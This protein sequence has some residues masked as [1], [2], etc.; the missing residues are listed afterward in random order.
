MA[1]PGIG[2]GHLARS[3]VAANALH[4]HGLSPRLLVHSPP[5]RRDD[6]AVLPH[7]FLAP[8]SP[9]APA[10]A[11]AARLSKAGA[12]LFDLYPP[13][14]SADLDDLLK[15][16]RAAG[17]R[18]V[19][20]DGLL[21]NAADLDLIFIPSFSF[22]PPADLPNRTRVLYGWDCYL[23]ESSDASTPWR[24]GQ[25][26]LALTGGSD[27]TG[28]GENLPGRLNAE[29]PEHAELDW[30]TGPFA[31]QPVW[32]D[33]PRIRMTNRQ[34][35]QGLGGLMRTAHY[36]LT[37]FGVSF[38]ELLRHGVPT[39]VFS[40]YGGKDDAELSGIAEAGVA[41]TAR[42]EAEAV[43]RLRALMA[44]D[45]LAAK[46]SDAALRRMATPGGERLAQAVA[47][48]LE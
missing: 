20:I 7:E 16:L 1:G 34:A 15:E 23:L 22:V 37:V 28:L 10:V 48:L 35:P 27:A 38:F 21:A 11:K 32:P 36:A 33:R 24:P 29:L 39:V 2:L 18:T 30:V 9:L 44:D 47:E 4:A 40:P 8:E 26:V 13:R 45:R 42:D 14:V 5:L 17:V 31:Q 43:A 3:V 25:R 12:V 46:L 6:L 41:L 19:A